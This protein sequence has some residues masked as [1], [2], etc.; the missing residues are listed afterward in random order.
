MLS[1]DE[2]ERWAGLAAFAIGKREMTGGCWNWK[3]H[4]AV[5]FPVVTLD[6]PYLWSTNK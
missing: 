4:S 6:L 5:Q 1:Q 2:R 3:L